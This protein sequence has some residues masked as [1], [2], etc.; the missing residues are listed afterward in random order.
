MKFHVI[1]MVSEAEIK[2]VIENGQA[3]RTVTGT[4]VKYTA[5]NNKLL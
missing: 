2:L 4:A 5:L 3:M 1:G